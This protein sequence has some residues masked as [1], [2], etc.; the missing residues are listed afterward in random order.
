MSKKID[1]ATL[2]SP[3]FAYINKETYGSDLKNVCR[4]NPDTLSLIKVYNKDYTDYYLHPIKANFVINLRGDKN[5]ALNPIYYG[6]LPSSTYEY[7]QRGT[8]YYIVVSANGNGDTRII[9]GAAP[10]NTLVYVDAC[11]NV[12]TS[13]GT[14]I[15]NYFYIDTLVEFLRSRGYIVREG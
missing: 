10:E 8:D 14:D 9:D 15:V 3:D 6:N 12:N 7:E 1:P 4:D 5:D 11:G 2:E 13:L